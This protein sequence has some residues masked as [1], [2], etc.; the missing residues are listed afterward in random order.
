MNYF[1]TPPPLLAQYP[2]AHPPAPPS[3]LPRPQAHSPDQ[4]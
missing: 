3:P 4:Y 1:A 2:L